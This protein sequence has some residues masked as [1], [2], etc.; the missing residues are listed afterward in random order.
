M[1]SAVEFRER[2][3]LLGSLPEVPDLKE[4]PFISFNLEETVRD[5]ILLLCLN[6]GSVSQ[7]APVQVII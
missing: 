2:A 7:I 5:D 4:V 1:K 6:L 3:S